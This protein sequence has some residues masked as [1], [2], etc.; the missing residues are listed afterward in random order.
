LLS[1]P[2]HKLYKIVSILK[3]WFGSSVD[4]DVTS[5]RYCIN[6]YDNIKKAG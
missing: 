5:K 4:H 6:M 3:T 2:N 1:I